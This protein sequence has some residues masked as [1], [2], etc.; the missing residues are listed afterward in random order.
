MVGRGWLTLQMRYL[1]VEDAVGGPP[2]LLALLFSFSVSE[3]CADLRNVYEVFH[4]LG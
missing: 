1:R 2:V 3:E 4:E